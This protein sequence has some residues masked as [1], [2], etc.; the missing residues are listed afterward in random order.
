MR[1]SQPDSNTSEALKQRQLTAH[2]RLATGL[3]LLMVLIYALMVWMSRHYPAPWIGYV[4]AFA[5]AGMVGALADWFAVTALF[6]HPLGLPIPHTNLIE[7]GKEAIGANLGDF[8][9]SNFLNAGT[10]RPYIL[11]LK[12]SGFAASWLGRQKN[13]ELLISEGSRLALELLRKTDEDQ[14][15]AF[16][17]KR[18]K[19]LLQ[20]LKLHLLVSNALGYFLD[21]RSE[22]GLVTL[23]AR[24]IAGFIGENET[25]VREKVKAESPFF[26]PGFVDRKLAERITSGL[27]SYFE[28]IAADPA[29]R[30]REEL[31]A[32]LYTFADQLKDEPRWETEFR[33]LSAAFLTE[34]K[35]REYALAAWRSLKVTLEAELQEPQSALARYLRRNIEEFQSRLEQDT[36]LQTKID[37]WIRHT[38]YRYILRNAR[39]VSLLIS[40]TIGNWPGRELSRKLELEV[41]KDLQFIRING[42]IVGGAVGL[43]IYT[44]TALFDRS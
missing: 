32:Q 17:A 44:V 23:L 28:E 8:V 20:E 16:I 37:G 9:V 14:V 13:T 18:G 39:Q 29:H 42:T 26:V 24:K 19:S 4:S 3:F 30:I 40:N 5:E 25:L 2:K 1:G 35:L 38:A 22:A 11:K 27:V 15:A 6:H 33:N 36:E 43:L 31:R 41:G 21:R 7:R 10:I 12:V 34:E